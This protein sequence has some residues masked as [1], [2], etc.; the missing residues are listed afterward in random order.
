MRQK[1][2]KNNAE[3]PK[4]TVKSEFHSQ[5]LVSSVIECGEILL[6]AITQVDTI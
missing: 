1:F 4:K 3:S 5:I 2:L 6:L